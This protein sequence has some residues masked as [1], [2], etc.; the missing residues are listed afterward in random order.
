MTFV[1]TVFVLAIGLALVLIQRNHRRRGTVPG[2]SQRLT[3]RALAVLLIGGG[4]LVPLALVEGVINER[5]WNHQLVVQEIAESWGARQELQGPI[6]L[7]PVVERRLERRTVTNDLGGTVTTEIPTYTRR[8][9]W[10][11]PEVL[12]IDAALEPDTKRRGIYEAL[13]YSGELRLSGFFERPDASLHSEAIDSVE[14]DQARLVVL[15]SDLQ[16]LDQAAPL[17]FAGQT[18]DW[19]SGTGLEALSRPGFHARVDL[20]PVVGSSE[21]ES[22]AS[23]TFPFEVSLDVRGSSGFFFAPWGRTTRAEV[24]SAWPDPSFQG[25]VLPWEHE[26]TEQGFVA[27]WEIP[28]LARD[29][30]QSGLFSGQSLDCTE[31]ALLTGVRLL[32]RVSLYSLIER[33][34]KYGILF[35]ALT[36][37]TFLVFELHL[38]SRLHYIQYGLIGAALALF[39]LTLLSLAEHVGFARAYLGAALIA[40]VLITGYTGS[41]LR[42]RGAAASIAAMLMALYGLLYTILHLTDFA[43]LM[44]TGLLTLVLALLMVATRDLGQLESPDDGRGEPTPP[45]GEELAADGGR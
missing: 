27:R 18:L 8:F 29:Y 26:V 14:W 34:A 39:F 21:V 22:E 45:Y 35:V 44:G 23:T 13:V 41:A 43:L 17:E 28:Q 42:S 3:V 20:S 1:L 19:E 40:I 37:M 30:G 10:A 32:E 12:E 38:G 9:L 16:S 7:V 25:A 11:L 31:G 5:Q 6:L 36:F 33:S 2:V 24:R 4:M 15:L